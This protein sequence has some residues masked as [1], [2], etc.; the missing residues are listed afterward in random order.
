MGI[1]D[2]IAGWAGRAC[3]WTL[4]S[5]LHRNASTLPGRVAMALDPGV[6]GSLAGK[7]ACGSIVVCGTNGKTT[8]NN[9]L[10]SALEGSGLSVF[11]N[12]AGANMESGVVTA[13]LPAGRADWGVFENDELST[14]RVVP[15][16]KPRY[17][18]L[19]NLFRDQLDR[20]GELDKIQ[21][22]LEDALASSPQTVLVYN[23]DDPLCESVALRFRAAGGR[24]MGFGID[25]DL[26][27]PGD[28][29]AGGAFCQRCP[30]PLTYAYRQYGQLGKYV[31]PECGFGRPELTFAAV[32]VEVGVDGVA[33]DACV[34][35]RPE[36]GGGA[37][38]VR[39][40]ARWGGTYMVYNL[41]AA[42][43]AASLVGVG[44]DAFQRV[45]DTYAPENG[46]LQ[47]FEVRGRR[48]T[49]NLAKNPTGYNQ[50]IAMLMGDPSPKIVYIVI[51]D[52]Y[53][54]GKDVS[55][56]WDVDFE[57]LGLGPEC[58]VFAGGTRANDMQVRLKYAGVDAVIAGSVGEVLDATEEVPATWRLWVLPNYSALSAVKSELEGMGA[59]R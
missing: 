32:N 4:R 19:L 59:A 46:R 30:S 45:L 10:A 13:L 11:C 31:C 24:A 18:V 29:V 50:N 37:G 36:G 15:K 48:T 53:N 41:L 35:G 34:G 22:T 40:R 56:L 9:V 8:T 26:H 23:A 54:D 27:L 43:A 2:S 21:R 58:R 28:R 47:R 14:V 25:E 38:T 17:F 16:V 39:L 5:L 52:D 20:C 3:A 49:L 44:A 55:W 33:F 42:Y 57:R 1:R 12:R 6:L 51:N 7:A